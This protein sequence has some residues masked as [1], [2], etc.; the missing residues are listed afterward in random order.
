[1]TYEKLRRSENGSN[2]QIKEKQHID[3]SYE[4]K[5][6]CR[7]IFN[8][9]IAYSQLYFTNRVLRANQARNKWIS[10]V[11]VCGSITLATYRLSSENSPAWKS[12]LGTSM[13]QLFQEKKRPKF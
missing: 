3:Y 11:D 4:P 5:A 12:T 8:F 7:P 9:F 6:Q 13:T 1:M 10:Y 2:L